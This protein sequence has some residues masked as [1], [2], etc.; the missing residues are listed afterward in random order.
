MKIYFAPLE[1]ITTYIFRSAFNGIYG[2]VDRYFTP[3]ISPSEK[4][5]MTPKEHK[6][7]APEN[8]AGLN[9]VPQILTCKSECFIDAAKELRAMGYGEVNLN[10][11]CPS[12]T[13]CAKGKGIVP[14][15]IG[16][17]LSVL[18]ILFVVVTFSAYLHDERA[19]GHSLDIVPPYFGTPSAIETS[20][21]EQ[22]LSSPS[23]T[24]TKQL[25]LDDVIGLSSKGEELV[26]EDL[27][28]FKGFEAGSGLYIVEYQIDDDFMLMVGGTSATGKPMYAHL[29]YDGDEYV[30]IMTEDTGAFIAA[31]S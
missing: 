9:L 2:N 6:D 25:T 3:F 29:I 16:L 20:G 10:L 7:V 24:G 22:D 18:E 19:P 14:G 31:H 28:E 15:T 12:G 26:W 21:S 17:I 1:G 11:G 30:D 13:V 27:S 4:C 8:N 5:P 23:I